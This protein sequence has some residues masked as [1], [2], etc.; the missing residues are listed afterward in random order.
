M[1]SRANE[2]SDEFLLDWLTL[3]YP[4]AV[5]YLLFVVPKRMCS[6]CREGHLSQKQHSCTTLTAQQ[7]LHRYFYHSLIDLDELEVTDQFFFHKSSVNNS[8]W[9]GTRLKTD[10]WLKKL[11]SVC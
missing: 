4:E 11:I 2:S 9:K 5:Q 7:M 6:A 1:V 8:V 10:Q 3:F